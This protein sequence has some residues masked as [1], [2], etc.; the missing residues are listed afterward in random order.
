M[1]SFDRNYR[2]LLSAAFHLYEYSESLQFEVRG[3]KHADLALL[4]SATNLRMSSYQSTTNRSL[5]L[6]RIP[7]GDISHV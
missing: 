1:S 2:G 3:A 6:L 7:T 5:P 4:V